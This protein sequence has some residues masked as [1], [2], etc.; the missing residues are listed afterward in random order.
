MWGGFGGVWCVCL[1]FAHRGEAMVEVQQMV[2]VKQ[3]R[4]AATGRRGRRQR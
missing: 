4:S 2:N 1:F 3:G